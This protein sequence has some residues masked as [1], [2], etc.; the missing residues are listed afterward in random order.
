MIPYFDKR[1][2]K[3]FIRGKAIRFC[4]KFTNVGID[5][6]FG[7]C[8]SVWGWSGWRGRQTEYPGIGMGGS[9]V[10]NLISEF[11]E[12]IG[13]SYHLTFDN[14]FTSYNLVDCLTS[15]GIACIGTLRSSWLGDA[16]LK[17]VKEMETLKRGYFWLFDWYLEW[18]GGCAM[19]R[20]QRRQYSFKQGWGA[21]T[22]ISKK[23]VK[24]RRKENWHWSAFPYQ[25]LQ[26]NNGWSG[27][28]GPK[29]GQISHDHPVQEVL[30]AYICI[31]PGRQY[32][33]SVARVSAD[34]G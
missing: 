2:A 13:S 20:Q 4:Y 27:P 12:E 33:A 32:P 7:L 26:Q 10:I 22:A 25:T 15:K 6:S 29:G 28:V 17:S 9:V 18:N 34:A 8:P 24:N 11:Q 16:P 3:Q 14:L 21:P 19:K 30:V 23:M 1:S 31:L 5:N